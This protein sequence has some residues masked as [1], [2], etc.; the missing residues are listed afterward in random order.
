MATTGSFSLSGGGGNTAGNDESLS[1]FETNFDDLGDTEA[2]GWGKRKCSAAQLTAAA[3]EA[4]SSEA[5]AVVVKKQEKAADPGA[6]ARCKQ[7]YQDTAPGWLNC[8]P[9]Q[10]KCWGHDWISEKTHGKGACIKAWGCK[11]VL[12]PDGIGEKGIF[13]GYDCAKWSAK[14]IAVGLLSCKGSQES[15]SGMICTKATVKHI[16]LMSQSSGMLMMKR[17]VC[18]G[19]QC[20]VFKSGMCIDVGKNV[21]SSISNGAIGA[22]MG[23]QGQA[24]AKL[25]EK[26]LVQYKNKLPEKHLCSDSRNKAAAAHAWLG[27]HY[28]DATKGKQ[29]LLLF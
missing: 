11:A 25:A 1:N 6:R 24:F 23:R 29:A 3:A 15:K 26:L 12:C 9:H 28:K 5:A 8:K 10:G 19:S 18:K 22:K 27:K 2:S 14:Q 4:A 16:E 20:F 7:T 17:T 13:M 21:W